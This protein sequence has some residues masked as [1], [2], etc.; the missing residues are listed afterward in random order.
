M[1]KKY[2]NMP[3]NTKFTQNDTINGVTSLVVV[4]FIL[5]ALLA[6]IKHYCDI[7]DVI[8]LGYLS[9]IILFI[10]IYAFFGPYLFKLIDNNP[11]KTHK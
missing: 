8:S 5:M 3:K 7:L 4:L 1:M 6:F 10:S 2:H 9:L 11:N